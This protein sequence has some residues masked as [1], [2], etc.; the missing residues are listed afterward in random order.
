MT[1]NAAAPEIAVSAPAYQIAGGKVSVASTVKNRHDAAKN[2]LPAVTLTCKIGSGKAQT[3]PDS[4]FLLTFLTATRMII[5]T[6]L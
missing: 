1:V 5:G 3:R 4:T 6:D 2:D